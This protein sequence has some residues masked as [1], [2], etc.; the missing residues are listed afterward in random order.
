MLLLEELQWMKKDNLFPP[1]LIFI[2]F[3]FIAR[4]PRDALL[5]PTSTSDEDRSLYLDRLADGTSK[6][7]QGPLFGPFCAGSYGFS[8]TVQFR[9]F[10]K[11]QTF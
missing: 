7:P 9:A 4:R 10:L 3:I 1:G 11:Q 5:E 8:V 2:I 6:P